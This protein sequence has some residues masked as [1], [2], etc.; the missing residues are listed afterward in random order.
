M[1]RYDVAQYAYYAV[2]LTVAILCYALEIWLRTPWPLVRE[3]LTK[4]MSNFTRRK[5]YDN[6]QKTSA[7]LAKGSRPRKSSTVDCERPDQQEAAASNTLEDGEHPSKPGKS[8]RLITE[9]STPALRWMTILPGILWLPTIVLA[10]LQLYH[11]GHDHALLIQSTS[12]WNTSAL[13]EEVIRIANASDLCDD[14]LPTRV[15]ADI[16]GE[17]IRAG[18]Y[19]PVGLA[20]LALTIGSF[21]REDS[22]IKEVGATQLLSECCLRLCLVVSPD[23][24]DNSPLLSEFQR[25]KICGNFAELFRVDF[26]RSCDCLHVPRSYRRRAAHDDVWKG[27]F[28][29]SLVHLYVRSDADLGYRHDHFDACLRSKQLPRATVSLDHLVGTC[30]LQDWCLRDSMVLHHYEVL[31]ICSWFLAGLLSY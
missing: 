19:L 17:G 27:G 11:S 22:G 31:H 26:S 7:T 28:V 14:S 15:N 18:V 1:A 24:L 9:W 23:K 6:D 2:F 10:L 5:A 21:H 20:L 13:C 12:K 16:G 3:R 4:F 30:R 8:G 25:D 29:R